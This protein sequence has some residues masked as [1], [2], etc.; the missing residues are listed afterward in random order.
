VCGI[1]DVE[2]VRIRQRALPFVNIGYDDPESPL[3]KSRQ[4]S[5]RLTITKAV[6]H[7]LGFYG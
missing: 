2:D 3:P 1:E 7:Q 4:H 5:L 6:S